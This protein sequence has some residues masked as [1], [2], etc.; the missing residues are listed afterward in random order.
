MTSGRVSKAGMFG[1]LCGVRARMSVTGKCISPMS[2]SMSP[3][4]SGAIWMKPRV[5]GA[6]IHLCRL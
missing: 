6:P 4:R 1:V 2:G 5:S 3:R